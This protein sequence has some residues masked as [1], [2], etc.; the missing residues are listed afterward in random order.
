M[1]EKSYNI[2]WSD[3]AARLAL[4][5]RIGPAAYNEAMQQHLDETVLRVTAGHKIRTVQ[6]RFGLLYSVG[7]T[8]N[9]FSTLEAAD[10]FANK[11]PRKT[12]TD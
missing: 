7:S 10:K 2:E 4:V 3:P 6:S 9:A 12:Q 5:E 11:N 8:G 1:A